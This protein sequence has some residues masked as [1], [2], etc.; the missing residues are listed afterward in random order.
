ME[1][2][3]THNHMDRL[4]ITLA[5]SLLHKDLEAALRSWANKQNAEVAYMGPLSRHGPK[6]MHWH[7]RRLEKGSGTVEATYVPN[8]G[9]FEVVVHTSRR[10]RW[11]GIAYPSLAS[12]VRKSLEDGRR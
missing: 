10:G 5:S 6:S 9:M 7:I 4:T 3:L 1:A 2:E 11:A 8:S 12:S